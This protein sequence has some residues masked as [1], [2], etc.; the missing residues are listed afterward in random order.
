MARS[1]LRDDDRVRGLIA[2]YRART[3]DEVDANLR[4]LSDWLNQQ[5]EKTPEWGMAHIA[6][7]RHDV[8]ELLDARLR[9]QVGAT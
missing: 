9:L 6:R 5:L 7:Y 3:T 4:G 8:N 2:N 1:L